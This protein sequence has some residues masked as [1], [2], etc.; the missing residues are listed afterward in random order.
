MKKIVVILSLIIS[1]CSTAPQYL[2]FDDALGT[3]MQKIENDLTEGSQ[4]AILDFKSDNE[5]LSSYIIEEMYDKL[6]NSGKLIIMERS[7]TNTIA[8]EVGYQ[9]SGEVDDS[10]I[11]DIGH[12]LGADYVVTGQITFSGEAYRLR[13]F[14]IDIEKGRRVASTSLN[15]NQNDRQINH[16][17]TTKT[18][19]NVQVTEAD[20]NM[21][22]NEDVLLTAIQ[23]LFKRIPRNSRILITD[24]IGT[25]EFQPRHI[26]SLI[27]NEARGMTVIIEEQRQA[28]INAQKELYNDYNVSDDSMPQLGNMVGAN[29]IIAG[30]VFG[31]SDSRRIVFRAVDVE[32]RQIISESCILFRKNNTELINNVESLLQRI[33]NSIYNKIRDGSAIAIINNSGTN[34]NADFVFDM[35]ENNLVNQSKYKIVIRTTS[36]ASDYIADLIQKEIEFQMSGN[37]SVDTVIMLGMAVGARYVMNIE[38]VNNG[39]NVKIF[40]VTQGNTIIEEI[41]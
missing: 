34:R 35:I 7:R 16:L 23:N 28:A 31:N 24:F 40:D 18:A 2:S 29:V 33:N 20:D 12:Q 17:I 13:V 10:Q 14:A 30:G 32:T 27:S 19:A 36:Y 15:I 25:N 8:M 26:Q 3:G 38:F 37:A 22:D 21:R 39:I 1:S 5:N 11:V 41:M 9:L 4:V 6:V